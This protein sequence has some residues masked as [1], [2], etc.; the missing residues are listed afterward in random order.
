MFEHFP[1]DPEDGVTCN[2]FNDLIEKTTQLVKED[3]DL[4]IIRK[5]KTGSVPI[6]KLF[7]VPLGV[8][9]DVSFD[10]VRGVR[11][12]ELQRAYVNFSPTVKRVVMIVRWWV[13]V[14]GLTSAQ[15]SFTSYAVVWMV[16]FYFMTRK[17][18]PRLPPVSVVPGVAD[19]TTDMKCDMDGVPAVESYKEPVGGVPEQEFLKIL[20]DMF[21]FFAKFQFQENVVS[22]WLGKALPRKDF[23]KPV[24]TGG[25]VV[26]RCTQSFWHFF[27][28]GLGSW[29]Y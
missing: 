19:T 24:V 15:K 1:E 8:S 27:S 7:S 11:N 2:D 18:H 26:G 4:L 6:L 22:P 10:N 29:D 17:E 9:V 13:K 14:R 28:N 20:K 3:N 23:E 25:G 16:L 12:T 21:E 5:I